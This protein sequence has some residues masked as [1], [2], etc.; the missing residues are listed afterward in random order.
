ME[1]N[2]PSDTK[3]PQK[4]HLCPSLQMLGSYQFLK[5]EWR[6]F[7]FQT[8]MSYPGIYLGMIIKQCCANGIELRCVSSF[9]VEMCHI[10]MTIFPRTEMFQT[11]NDQ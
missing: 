10:N 9:F 4:R 6:I 8:V 2:N 1:T 11:L 5:S 7:F 3:I